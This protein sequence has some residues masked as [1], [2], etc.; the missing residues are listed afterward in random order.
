ML[1]RLGCVSADA[2]ELCRIT[3]ASPYGCFHGEA[4]PPQPC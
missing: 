4:G 1:T 2:I 3:A